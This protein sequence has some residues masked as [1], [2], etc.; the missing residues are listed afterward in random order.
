MCSSD[1]HTNG[2]EKILSKKM[3]EKIQGMKKVVI[4]GCRNKNQF[5]EFCRL[6]GQ[7]PVIIYVYSP[8]KFR[9]KLLQKRRREDFGGY[10]YLI[11]R[12]RREL[13]QGLKY[14]IKIARFRISN[15]STKKEL[16][17]KTLKTMKIINR[18][19]SKRF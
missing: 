12:D 16:E 4:I 2:R 15:R 6:A 10:S 17:R 9:W 13:E 11:E 19:N 8:R 7:K 5:L 1:L 3:W 18:K 14:M